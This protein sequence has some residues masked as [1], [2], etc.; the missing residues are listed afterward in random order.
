MN[1]KIIFALFFLTLGI[2]SLFAQ[3]IENFE[4]GDFNTYNWQL[5]GDADWLVTTTSPHGGTYCAQGGD[6]DDSQ[7]TELSITKDVSS[8]SQISFYWKV[9]SENNY[10]YLRSIL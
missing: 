5:S 6:I 10:D 2:F 1:T 7:T 8:A 3:D 4:S 9:D